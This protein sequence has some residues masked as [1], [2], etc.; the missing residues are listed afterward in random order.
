MIRDYVKQ[1]LEKC[2]FADL[3]N[4][5]ENTNSYKIKK[6]SKPKYEANKMYLIRVFPTI[7]NNES[8]VL[9]TNWNNSTAPTEPILL[10]YVSK[11]QG[12]MIYVDTVAYDGVSHKQLNIYWSG[13]LITDEIEQLKAV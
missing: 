9:A 8:N 1:Q 6:Y 3:T 5:D 2:S 10:A 4:F 13:W 7:V 11:V 12:K